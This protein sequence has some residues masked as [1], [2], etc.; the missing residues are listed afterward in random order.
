MDVDESSQLDEDESWRTLYT[1]EPQDGQSAS[2]DAKKR[3]APSDGEN[4]GGP[5]AQSFRTSIPNKKAR[6][7]DS[8][9]LNAEVA[10]LTKQIL[11]KRGPT[12]VTELVLVR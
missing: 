5:N 2:A 4:A 10:M 6:V 8:T 7:N 3:R 12:T 9:S 11:A 1:G